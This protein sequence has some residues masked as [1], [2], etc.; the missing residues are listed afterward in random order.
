MQTYAKGGA[1][2]VVYF[3]LGNL[4]LAL[5]KKLSMHH[6]WTMMNNLNLVMFMLKSNLQVPPVSEVFFTQINNFLS[7]KSNWTDNAVEKI[8]N[9]VNSV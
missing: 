5:L 1:T 3:A 4:G 7:M 2:T 6:I 8:E 9:Y